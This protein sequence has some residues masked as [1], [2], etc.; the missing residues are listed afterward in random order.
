MRNGS[1]IYPILY[2]IYYLSGRYLKKASTTSMINYIVFKSLHPFSIISIKN[3]K[4]KSVD[5]KIL[6]LK[7]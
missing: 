6:Y 4:L 7:Y 3:Y 1:K 5:K 2:K